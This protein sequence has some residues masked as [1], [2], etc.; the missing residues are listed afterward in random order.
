MHHIISCDRWLCFSYRST[1]PDKGLDVSTC[2][3]HALLSAPRLLQRKWL[4]TSFVCVWASRKGN[5]LSGKIKQCVNE[6][7]DQW[8]NSFEVIDVRTSHKSF[9][10]G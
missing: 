4:H 7:A 1:N 2:G 10:R 9:R 5:I 6:K 3:S 8:K